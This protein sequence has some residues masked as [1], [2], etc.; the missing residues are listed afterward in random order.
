MQWGVL[1][2]VWVQRTAAM[3]CASLYWVRKGRSKERNDGTGQRSHDRRELLAGSLDTSLY[4]Q[5]V[6]QNNQ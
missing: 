2:D 3:Q 1:Y 6:F 4:T 5:S